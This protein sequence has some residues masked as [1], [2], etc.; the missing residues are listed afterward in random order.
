MNE[1]NIYYHTLHNELNVLLEYVKQSLMDT[2]A[3]RN[4]TIKS[5]IELKKLKENYINYDKM[6]SILCIAFHNVSNVFYSL[7][8]DIK[9]LLDE[10]DKYID[11]TEISR[12]E[13]AINSDIMKIN[14]YDKI[15]R[16]REIEVSLIQLT[17]ESEFSNKELTID[18]SS[19]TTKIT[20][21]ESIKKMIETAI[22]SLDIDRG[23]IEL[24]SQNVIFDDKNTVNIGFDNSNDFNEQSNIKDKALKVIDLCNKI[25][26][27]IQKEVNT[28]GFEFIKLQETVSMI[29]AQNLEKIDKANSFFTSFVSGQYD[30]EHQE[31]REQ[32]KQK[33][34]EEY[35]TLVKELSALKE[36]LPEY[37]EDI[38]KLEGRLL[39]MNIDRLKDEQSISE[40]NLGVSLL[41]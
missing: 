32:L 12:V 2:I 7:S 20:V 33:I 26:E 24:K 28:T 30:V 13:S 16:L 39:G 38:S 14:Y 5:S 41:I 9:Q 40:D 37:L 29:L 1:E 25:R 6:N 23:I 31:E 15:Q 34:I 8:S 19:E 11:E 3:G 35:D 21:E 17:Y 27:E 36:K 4:S 22:E 18:D 10:L